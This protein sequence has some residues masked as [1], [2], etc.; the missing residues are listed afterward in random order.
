MVKFRTH[1]DGG[2]SNFGFKSKPKRELHSKLM[3][4]SSTISQRSAALIAG[5]SLLLMAIVAGVTFGYLH[6]NLVVANDAQA[7]FENLQTS[8]GAFKSEIAGWSIIFLLDAIVA[9]ALFHFFAKANKGVSFFSSFLRII[10]TIILGV[11]IYNLPQILAV[12]NDQLAEAGLGSATDDVMNYLNSFENIWSNGLIVF[13]LHLMALGYLAFT[14]DYV[15]K[16]WGVLLILAG[17]SYSYIHAMYAVFPNMVE[18]LITIEAVL[19]I[20]M[21]IGEVGFAIWLIARGGKQKVKSN[22][23]SGAYIA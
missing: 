9:W 23:I 19:T 11:A 5:I 20:P 14:A 17:I 7:T 2:A 22:Q 10:Y 18:Y 16:V 8:Q 1:T 15:P 3:K 21:T 6:G 4:N 13:G 12:I